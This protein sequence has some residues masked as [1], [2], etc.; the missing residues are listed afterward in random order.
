MNAFVYIEGGPT[1]A[2]SKEGIIRCREGFRKL[3]D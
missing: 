2:N 1:G 3:L